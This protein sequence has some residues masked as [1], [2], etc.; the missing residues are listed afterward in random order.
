MKLCASC[1]NGLQGS[2]E[3]CPV[4]DADLADRDEIGGDELVGMVVADKYELVQLVGDGAMGWVYRGVHQTLER[5]VAVKLLKTSPGAQPEQVSRFE[6]E[7][8]AVSRLNHP[9]IVS[10]IDFGRSPGGL[11]YL[12]TE[13]VVGN[14][15]ADLLYDSGRLP[16]GR[17]LGIFHQLLAGVE[18]AHSAGVIHRDLK[19]D[20]VVVTPL[21]SGDDFVKILDFGIAAVAE[22]PGA[23]QTAAGPIMGTPGFMAPETVLNGMSNER[24]DIYAL[25]VVLYELLVGMPPF[26]H[27]RPMVLLAMHANQ[28]PP[29]L[30]EVAPEVGFPLELEQVLDQALTKDPKDRFG[31]VAELRAAVQAGVN[32]M[33][34]MELGCQA[35]TRPID[36]DTGLCNLHGSAWAPSSSPSTPP[37]TS[38]TP[39]VTGST[40]PMTS[41][42]PPISSQRPADGSARTLVSPDSLGRDELHQ[43]V[44]GPDVV[45]RDEEAL[46]IV[47]FLLGDQPLLE[48]MGEPGAGKT[49]ALAGLAATAE[50][51][52]YRVLRLQPDERSASR[53]W[54]PFRRLIG[55]VLGCG[56]VPATQRTVQEAAAPLGLSAEQHQGLAALFGLV[57]ARAPEQG[58]E[59]ARSIH[60]SAAA[61]LAALQDGAAGTCLVADDPLDFD[62]ASQRLLRALPQLLGRR[63]TKLAVSSD[64]AFFPDRDDRVVLRL[65]ALTPAGIGELLNR[66]LRAGGEDRVRA[67]VKVS[68]GNAL[69]VRYA[70][71]A[72]GEGAKVGAGCT[73]PLGWRIRQLSDQASQTLQVVC[74]AGREVPRNL[75]AE[76]VG[77][78]DLDPALDRLVDQGLLR[79]EPGPVAAFSPS[80]PAVAATALQLMAGPDRARLHGQ[81]L[82]T[83]RD[84]A[85]SVFVL[86]HQASAAQLET[87]AED[88]L[89]LLVAA[90][91]EACRWADVET[92]ALVHYRQ[93]VHTARWQLLMSEEDERYLEL[94]LRLGQ[95]LAA[96]GHRRAAEVVLREVVGG[97]GRHNRLL[98]RARAALDKLPT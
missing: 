26:E 63:L 92:A 38:S 25:G 22:V 94:S 41:S 15:L 87:L 5:S 91:D 6:Q 42:T 82:A 54:Y 86:A 58:V 47:D 77:D 32:R 90:G 53:P 9:H 50:S 21:R 66:A 74:A 73:D 23:S 4:C 61:V 31:S 46:T 68:G 70:I 95:T 59:L 34:R 84:Q 11:F 52:D 43:R 79:A 27:E 64:G 10:V 57:S 44:F 40:P 80:H 83:L 24:S 12:V 28:P 51:L 3:R 85:A 96:T 69:G 2:P 7:A 48:V 39:P 30:R 60:R 97:A 72:L 18:E 55:E 37:M 19:P 8:L 1:H 67:I 98:A 88:T 16:V 20:N 45:C 78:V 65:S 14:T 33:G 29:R 89:D 75:V 81:L 17:A 49:T 35:C 13:F 71:A 93:A 56:P 62:R 36:P 76:L